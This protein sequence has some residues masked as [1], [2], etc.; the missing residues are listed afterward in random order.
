MKK[1][2]SI[3][4]LR[5]LAA[6]LVVAFHAAER[7]GIDFKIGQCGVDIF[8][9][10]SGFIM[11]STTYEK[12][13]STFQFLIKRFLRIAPV[14]WAATMATAIGFL[15]KPNFFFGTSVNFPA[16]VKSAL[17]IPYFNG[18]GKIEPVLLQGWTLNIEMLFYLIFSLFVWEKRRVLRVGSVTLLISLLVIFGLIIKQQNSVLQTYTNNIL[19]EFVF[20]VWIGWVYTH[21]L[22]EKVHIGAPLVLIG[23]TAYIAMFILD[24]PPGHWRIIMWGVPATFIA[25][26]A[27]I[28]ENRGKLPAV[29][30][31]RLL[32]DASYS[33]Y[34]W[35]GLVIVVIDGIWLRLGLKEGVT[36][37]I[38]S[39]LISVAA[40][41]GAYAA[42]EKPLTKILK[43]RWFRD[44]ED[45][46]ILRIKYK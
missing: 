37:T 18:Y 2:D 16:L 6:T 44:S 20:G 24:M 36:A 22:L 25:A 29:P 39:T 12:N 34:L 32:G 23:F 5:A 46:N 10:I 9:I 14:Y 35:H 27:L 42:L 30:F 38:V 33:I 17:F 28:L 43:Y 41:L 4:Y 19:M 7:N 11:W 15:I 3:Q 45:G 1:I 26:G 21:G 40:S 13:L 31:L 8:F